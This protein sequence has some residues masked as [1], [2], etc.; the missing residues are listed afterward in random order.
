MAHDASARRLALCLKIMAL[1]ALV[2]LAVFAVRF[3]KSGSERLADMDPRIVEEQYAEQ[4]DALRTL[5]LESPADLS[6]PEPLDPDEQDPEFSLFIER[7]TAWSQRVES[8]EG[9]FD[10]PAILG[11]SVKVYL[12]RHSTSRLVI[13][14]YEPAADELSRTRGKAGVDRPHVSVWDAGR[15]Q[16]VKYENHILDE[17]GVKKG[18]QLVLDLDSLNVEQPPAHP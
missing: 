1:A 12:P 13:K 3:I 7:I 8:F 5:A 2:I 6:P 10:D 17:D 16:V 15:M 18:Y 9:L 4:L 14:D 11:A